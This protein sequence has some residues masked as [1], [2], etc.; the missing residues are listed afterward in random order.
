MQVLP[1]WILAVGLYIVFGIVQQQIQHR[2][3]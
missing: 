1:E 2:K 3:S